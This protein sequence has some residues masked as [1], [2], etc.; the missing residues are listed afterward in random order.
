MVEFPGTRAKI[1]RAE[2]HLRDIKARVGTLEESYSATIQVNPNFGYKEIKYDLADDRAGQDFSLIIGDALHNLK[3]ALDYAW[4]ATLQRHAP[5]AIG[6]KTQFPIHRKSDSLESALKDAKKGLPKDLVSL[7]L[8]DIKPHEA[9]HP[10]LWAIKELNILD[11]H[12]LLLTVFGYTSIV[13]LEMENEAGEP[14]PGYVQAT[15]L[16]PP[17]FISIPNGWHVKN[18]GKPAIAVLFNEGHSAQGMEVT[19]FLELSHM[20]VLQVVKTLEAFT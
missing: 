14:E 15:I 3:G 17:W 8:N 9:G 11:K 7:M 5:H 13:G 16:P 20:L 1:E 2:Q 18:N 10:T 19:S 6:D 12:R 4:I